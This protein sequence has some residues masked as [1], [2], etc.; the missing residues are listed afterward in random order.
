VTAA[1]DAISGDECQG[2][3]AAYVLG[4]LPDGELETFVTHM[5]SCAICRE[6][7]AALQVVASSLAV[8]APQVS[9][10]DELKARVM[11]TVQSEAELRR[12]HEPRLQAARRAGVSLRW[13]PALA[14]GGALAAV[15]AAIVIGVSSGGDSGTRVVRA[16]VT[17]AS[18]TA[19]LRVRGGHAEL[20]IAGMPQTPPD[21]V[22]EVWVK[23]AGA[24]QPTDALFTVTSSGNATVGVPGSVAGVK[25]VMVTAEPLG[26]SKAPTSTPVIV[27]RVS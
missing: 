4:A 22:Y 24:P 7:V 26:G 11:A 2:D 15:I 17:P 25:E 18:A 13:R 20:Q 5:Q 1:D 10:P 12:A 9:A 3:A 27:A 8:A 14:L 21:R 6:E 19:S 23:R 16:Q